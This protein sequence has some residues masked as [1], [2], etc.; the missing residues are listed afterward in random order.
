MSRLYTDSDDLSKG[1]YVPS[2]RSTIE[3]DVI[4]PVLQAL[5]IGVVGGLALGT[6]TMLIGFGRAGWARLGL[7][8]TVGSA[9]TVFVLAMATIRMVLDHHAASVVDPLRMAWER[10]LLA[11]DRHHARS[12]D[13]EPAYVI[14]RGYTPNALPATVDHQVRAI[15][16]QVDRAT[17]RL[18]EF[19]IGTWPKG[20]SVSRRQCARE[21][22][23]RK[24]W[25]RY[26]GGMRGMEGQES[27]RGLLDRA[28]VVES[29]S[30]G[31][32]ICAPLG[33]ALSI[34]GPLQ[35]YAEAKASIVVGRDGLGMGRDKRGVGKVAQPGR[36]RGIGDER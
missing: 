13:E 30:S 24:T 15:T 35:A 36:G 31:W 33:D 3:S 10:L 5:A 34:T 9:G 20:P 7:A 11:M 16:P 19:I 14:T 22:F 1:T 27:G 17:E 23:S 32:T 12:D 29:T 8:A 18:Y 4:V 25:E 28:G 6:G 21:G 2:Q 26:V